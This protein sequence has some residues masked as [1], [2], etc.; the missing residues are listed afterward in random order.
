MRRALTPAGRYAAGRR[1]EWA[2]RAA[3][4]AA[5]WTV[6]RVAGSRTP[7]DLVALRADAPPVLVQAKRDG[8]IAP[9]ERAA[10][11]ACAARVGG[12]PV[13]AFPG[14]STREPVT[15]AVVVVPDDRPSKGLRHWVP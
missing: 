10:L 12:L 4:E 9:A 7:V 13:V 11:V 5:G 2:C 1:F 14:P 6:W 3:L 15:W 8:W